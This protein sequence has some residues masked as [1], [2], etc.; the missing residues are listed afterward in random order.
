MWIGRKGT[1]PTDRKNDIEFYYRDAYVSR[2]QCDLYERDGFFWIHDYGINVS[3]FRITKKVS[4]LLIKGMILY[5]G[6]QND[7]CFLVTRVDNLSKE[8]VTL[9][10]PGKKGSK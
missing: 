5:I 2:K 6:G 4:Y 3:R 9:E 10:R 7:E 1:K 8:L